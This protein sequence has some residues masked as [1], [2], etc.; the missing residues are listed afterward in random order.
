MFFPIRDDQ[1][2]FSKPYVNYFII[3]LNVLV[4]VLFELPLQ[5]PSCSFE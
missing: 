1:P 3:V 2:T 5:L 4:F